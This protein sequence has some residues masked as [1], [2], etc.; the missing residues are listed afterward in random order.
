MS[1]HVA[2][3]LRRLVA[4]R[5]RH[6]CEY[7][8]IRESDTYYGCQVDHVISEKHGGPTVAD[9][10]AF[11]CA[12]CNRFKGADIATLSSV[13]GQLTRLYHPRSDQWTDHFANNGGRLRGLTEIGRA[14]L[15]L[16][17]VN[18]DDRVLER[19]ALIAEGRY[20]G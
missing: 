13:T 17:R 2:A 16:L 5:A 10:L 1:G 12:F 14:T 9:N 4:V 6:A 19:E 15:D 3:A 7:C 8:R 18:A 20:P 11:A